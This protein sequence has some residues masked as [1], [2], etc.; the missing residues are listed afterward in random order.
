MANLIYRTTSAPTL[1]GA[2]TV[3]NSP[4]T[5]L[6]VDSNFKSVDTD[7]QTRATTVYVDSVLAT[8]VTVSDA[9]AFAIALG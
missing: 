6:E 8:K 7:I 4:L 5:N 1:P 3:K 9:M 2:T